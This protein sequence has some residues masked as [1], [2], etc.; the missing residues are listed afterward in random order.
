MGL[1]V[2]MKKT[3]VMIFQKK[4]RRAKQFNFIYNN[5]PL[6]IVTEYTYLGMTISASGSF[7]K[8]VET[9]REKMKRALAAIRKQLVLSKHPVKIANKISESFLLPILT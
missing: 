6:E 9:L 5:H 3:K 8:E 1:N 7:Q 2:N 4:A